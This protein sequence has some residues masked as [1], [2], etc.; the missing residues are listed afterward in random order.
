MAPNLFQVYLEVVRSCYKLPCSASQSKR[1]RDPSQHTA[2]QAHS[3]AGTQL[4][5]LKGAVPAI[6]FLCFWLGACLP[7]FYFLSLL[8]ESRRGRQG[9]HCLENKMGPGGERTVSAD[10][11]VSGWINKCS[12]LPQKDHDLLLFGPLTALV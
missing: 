6:C 1:V 8:L 12:P 7:N 2:R 3:L 11:R 9:D 4:G 5:R 10:R